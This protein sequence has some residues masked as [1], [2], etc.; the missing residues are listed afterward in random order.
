MSALFTDSVLRDIALPHDIPLSGESVFVSPCLILDLSAREELIL[1]ILVR[2]SDVFRT[3]EMVFEMRF[4]DV[5]LCCDV[6]SDDE[7]IREISEPS[8]EASWISASN[9]E[10]CEVSW[11][12]SEKPVFDALN[13]TSL[14][15]VLLKSWLEISWFPFKKGIMLH[16]FRS[17]IPESLISD[18]LA[19]AL[20]GRNVL[21]DLSASGLFWL[22][23]AMSEEVEQPG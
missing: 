3:R 14:N 15:M 6:I 1:I 18:M 20:M 2:L 8:E 23:V 12:C 19:S 5:K 22:S 11:N 21:P 7:C 10:R 13:E 4:G 16:A 17:E 9:S